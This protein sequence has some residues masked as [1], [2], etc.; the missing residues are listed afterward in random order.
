MAPVPKSC[1]YTWLLW[2]K[3]TGPAVASWVEMYPLF[4]TR[5]W[6]RI[7]GLRGRRCESVR[8][9]FVPGMRRSVML[10]RFGGWAREQ[11]CGKSE[12]DTPTQAALIGLDWS[13][14]S[15]VHI[16]KD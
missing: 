13:N 10:R 5:V 11:T 15:A 8:K 3:G 14:G 4:V 7:K 6:Y 16:E 9:V 12:V 2:G 1:S